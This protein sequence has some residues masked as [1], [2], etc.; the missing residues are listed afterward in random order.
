VD[1]YAN[2][3]V[4]PDTNK[5]L[6]STVSVAMIGPYLVRNSHSIAS[7]QYEPFSVQAPRYYLRWI[8]VV[9]R[10]MVNHLR[11]RPVSLNTELAAQ[12]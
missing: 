3:P 11:V 2:N 10:Q 5:T 12:S 6:S 7:R 4:L 1:I 8:V 9:D